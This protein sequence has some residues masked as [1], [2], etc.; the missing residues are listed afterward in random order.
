[1]AS[2]GSRRIWP[3]W[4]LLS[5]R[6]TVQSASQGAHPVLHRRSATFPNCSSA[7][8][9]PI[10]DTVSCWSTNTFRND[11]SRH[12]SPAH[13][14]AALGRRAGVSAPGSEARTAAGAGPSPPEVATVRANA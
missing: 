2:L 3:E 14:L 6:R 5:P 7:D 8:G 12:G 9:P 1:G 10:T 13:R 11:G 4:H